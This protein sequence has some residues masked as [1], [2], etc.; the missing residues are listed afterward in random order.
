MMHY[1]F[2]VAVALFVIGL[3]VVGAIMDKED[4]EDKE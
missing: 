2:M 3:L 1:F 4:M